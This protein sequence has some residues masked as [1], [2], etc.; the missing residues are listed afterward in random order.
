MCRVAGRRCVTLDPLFVKGWG[1]KGLAEFYLGRLADATQS[2]ETGLSIDPDHQVLTDE[3]KELKKRPRRPTH[4][5][6]FAPRFLDL[7]L[8]FEQLEDP[9]GLTAAYV[10]SHEQLLNMQVRGPPRS[11]GRTGRTHAAT[12]A[13]G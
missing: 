10:A 13:R 4:M 1:R 2:Y 5:L 8:L 12:P 11:D 9:D 3:L 7:E 6:L